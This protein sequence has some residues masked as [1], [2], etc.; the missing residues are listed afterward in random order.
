MKLA[1]RSIAGFLRRPDP[2]VRAALVYG[3]DLGLVHERAQLLA[4]AVAEDP[5]DPFRVVELAAAQLADDPARLADE[6]AALSFTGGRRV[7]RISG[8]SERLT[9]LLQRFLADPLGDALIVLEAGDLGRS[10]G[11]RRLFEDADN[12]AALAC[13]GDDADAL[14]G[15]IAAVLGAAGLRLDPAAQDYLQARLGGDRGVSRQELT[16][17]V[18]Y[19][20]PDAGTIR[21]EDVEA[22]IGDSA[23]LGLDDVCFA[24][25]G[26]DTGALERALARCFTAG[27]GPVAVLRAMQR[28]IQRLHLVAGLQQ[29]GTPIETALKRLRPPLHFKRSALF[30]AQL[31]QWPVARLAQALDILTEAEIDCKSTGAADEALCRWALLRLA[32]AA[33]A[34]QR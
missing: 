26:G 15:L 31:R 18:T 25:S 1:P 33:R 22:C 14:E 29:S 7:V 32:G 9:G 21:L 8:T 5:N 4:T 19:M 10:S 20:G 28:H 16:K 6:A 11:L 24:T 17:L 34:A 27:D 13:Y 3:P 2:G 12:A 23:A 30:R